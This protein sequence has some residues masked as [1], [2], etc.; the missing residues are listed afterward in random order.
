MDT[1]ILAQKMRRLQQLS[2][3]FVWVRK[4]LMEMS[5]GERVAFFY[6]LKKPNP[7][8]YFER[9]VDNQTRQAGL[10]MLEIAQLRYELKTA[11]F[12]RKRS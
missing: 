10:L 9:L 3:E 2:K 7:Q 5:E 8:P 12:E 1:E 11:Y 6:H 4:W